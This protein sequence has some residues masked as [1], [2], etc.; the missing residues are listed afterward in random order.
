[1]NR[2]ILA[3][4]A[5]A[6]LTL[7]AAASTPAPR[8]PD[9][10]ERAQAELERAQ[11]ELQKAAREF[12]RLAREHKLDHPRAFAYA[13]ATDPDRA[14]LG[15]TV[16]KG[17]EDKGRYRGVL[18]TGITPGGG[19][20]KAGLRSGDLL[21]EANGTKLEAAVG[22]ARD[23]KKRLLE[24]MNALKPGDQVAVEYERGGKRHKATVTATRPQPPP[25]LGWL[26]GEHDVLLPP[27]PPLPPMAPWA[28]QAP[29]AAGGLQLARIDDGLAV[30]FKTKDGVLVV[31]APDG[32]TLA[33]RSGDVIRRIN[34]RSVASPVAAWEEITSAGDAALQLQV[35]REGRELTLEGRLPDTG[36]R[37]IERRIERR[38]NEAPI[39]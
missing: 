33:L 31:A 29:R 13:F 6:C 35:V 24:V 15:V 34:G 12:A 1:M 3:A 20:D 4:L 14:M 36:P 17:P 7:E 16:A 27:V 8:A 2:L 38:G 19:A 25:L 32:G 9:D 11:A 28:P 10:V 5:A 18:L 22:E 23:P 37:R 30:Y 21:L 26:D 39:D